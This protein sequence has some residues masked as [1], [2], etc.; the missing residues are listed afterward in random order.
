MSK[1]I[2]RMDGITVTFGG[3]HA[4]NGFSVDVGP[5]TIHALIG[6]NGAGKTTVYNCISGF[7]RPSSGDI[8]FD[9]RSLLKVEPHQVVR[10]GIAR[11]FQNIETCGR[12]TVLEN[13]LIGMASAIPGY[14]PL[15]PSGRRSKIEKAAVEV[16]LDLLEQTGL[17]DHRE[18]LAEQLDFGHQKMLE[19]ARALASKPRLLLLDEPAAGLRNREIAML[20]ALLVKLARERCVTIVLVEHVMKLVMSIADRITV[21]NFGHKIADGTPAE[22]RKNPAVIE[23]YLGKPTDA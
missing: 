11:T 19:M 20:D 18:T 10:L 7:Y 23:A 1:P 13:V 9:G 16:A 8:Q 12:L 6:P 21:L 15:A 5:G 2:L 3:L 4:L 17:A 14:F 22:V